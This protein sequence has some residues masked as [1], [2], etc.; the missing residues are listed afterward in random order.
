[1][2]VEEKANKKNKNINQNRDTNAK[3][4]VGILAIIANLVLA[5]G[6]IITG[7]ITKS[8]AILA[9]GINS[10]TDVIAS[11]ISFV[12]I[13]ASEKPADKKHP[14]GHGKAEVIS[15]FVITL[16]IF[17]SGIYIIYD[18]IMNFFSKETISL[19]ILGFTVMGVSALINGIMS[20]IKIHY[21][22]KHDSV[23]LISDGVHSRIDLLVSITIFIGLFFINFY[24]GIDTILALLVGSYI[25][26]ESL[27]LGKE[28]TDSLIGVKADEE[29]ENKIKSIVKEQKVELSNLKTQK[30]GSE[31]TAD[32]EVKLPKDLDINKAEKLTNNL[33]QKLM[34]KISKLKYVAIQLKSH[35]FSS[36]YYR[37]RYGLGKGF[38]WQKK[39]RFEDKIDEAK[40]AGPG[41]YCICTECD[42][43]EPHKRGHP[44]ASKNC[45]KCGGPMTR[46]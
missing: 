39:G 1:M 26:K 40:G 43:K 3:Y 45:P 20:Q 35:E 28:T 38:G 32:L 5:I 8:S 29:T 2:V 9:D 14:Y 12:G 23:S 27:K 25:I 11:I 36:K 30:I 44:C 46:G 17:I 41:G 19:G 24:N 15:G 13:K 31:V 4:I 42:Y 16:I 22:K 7:S 33:R 34:E 10:S 18:A 6:K 21:G 37:P